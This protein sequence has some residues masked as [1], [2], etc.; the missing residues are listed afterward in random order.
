M[1]DYFA[2]YGLSALCDF[3]D[4][5]HTITCNIVIKN[6]SA[7][8]K[9]LIVDTGGTLLQVLTAPDFD[10]TPAFTVSDNILKCCLAPATAHYVLTID[11]KGMVPSDGIYSGTI[12]PPYPDLVLSFNIQHYALIG[13]VFNVY[14][15][16]Q[17]LLISEDGAT[18]SVDRTKLASWWGRFPT[19]ASFMP[20]GDYEFTI[21]SFFGVENVESGSLTYTV[22]Q[23]AE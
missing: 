12:S 2:N 7:G 10:S 21:S 4:G 3:L 23:E 8:N 14:G 15:D 17:G 20:A 9:Q 1:T 22:Q 19:E 18:W 11:D 13:R 6:V 5:D 16:P